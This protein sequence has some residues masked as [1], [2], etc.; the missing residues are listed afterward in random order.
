MKKL[1]NNKVKLNDNN[2]LSHISFY[3]GLR[4]LSIALN[5]EFIVPDCFN[6]ARI[7]KELQ[8]RF[9]VEDA[10]INTLISRQLSND[11]DVAQQFFWLAMLLT[12]SLLQALKVPCIS[13]GVIKE[14][15]CVDKNRRC[16][17]VACRFPAV[18][19]YSSALTN[20][21]LGHACRLIKCFSNPTLTETEISALLE[22]LHEQFIVT[23]KKRVPGG[24]STIPILKSAFKLDIP[25]MHIGESYYQLGWGA[26]SHISQRSTTELD[27]AIGSRISQHK[28]V[29]AKILKLA[30]LPAPFHFF[31]TTLNQAQEAANKIGF[32]VVIKPADR[33]RG[34]GVTVG[35]NN[36]E[37]LNHAFNH[38]SKFSKNILVERQVPGIC[39]RI[40]L[41]DN[42][43][44]YTVARLAKSVEGDGKHTVLELCTLETEMENRRAK[45]LRKKPCLL[46]ELTEQTLN[47]Q[48]LNYQ[49]I[50]ENGVLV[51]LRPIESTE[52]GG[53]PKLLTDQVHPDNLRIA[54]QAAQLMNLNVAG[55]DLI[56]EDI[57]KP[58]YE[59]GAV[60]NEV[61]F[62]PFLGLRLDYQRKGVEVLVQNLFKEGGRIPIEVFIGNDE[63]LKA[64]RQRQQLLAKQNLQSFVTTHLQTFNVLGE[65]RLAPAS[66]ALFTRCRMLLMNKDVESLL[67]VVQTDELLSTGLPVDS[68]NAIAV[69]NQYLVSNKSLNQPARANSAEMIMELFKPYCKE[70]TKDT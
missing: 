46:D 51:F 27:S 29:T 10:P 43:H 39:H 65:I 67:I 63:A 32:P 14:I 8:A 38:A 70:G 19:N 56:S 24:E 48:G 57:S 28:V 54:F 44:L 9:D 31:V 15:K 20:A 49:S 69:V 4:Q 42:T 41:A 59:N 33:D 58:W 18:E 50:P 52:W 36:A 47:A 17:K 53:T 61:N 45:H 13:L 55:V 12:T 26:R 23:T 37:S 64:A 34:E 68:V 35:I 6:F 11:E 2:Q 62:A 30:G 22:E 40:L 21:C 60:I 1:E 7:G 3:N 16:F 66:A 25:F 5:A